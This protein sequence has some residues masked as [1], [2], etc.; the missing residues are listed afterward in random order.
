MADPNPIRPFMRAVA[1]LA[2]IAAAGAAS[3]VQAESAFG[4]PRSV[5]AKYDVRWFGILVYDGKFKVTLNEGSYK[6]EFT[7]NARGPVDLATR[8]RIHWYLSGTREGRRFFPVA[9]DQHYKWR[10]K[11][12]RITMS[13]RADGSVVTRIVPPESPGKRKPVPADM[14]RGTV[15]PVSALLNAVHAQ[16]AGGRCG[17]TFRAFEG[18]RR[19]DAR[20][21][22]VRK[23]KRPYTSL[24]SIPNDAQLCHFHIDRLAGF[25][26]RHMRNY[27]DPLP[28]AELW[29]V[30]FKQH[31]FWLPV[32]IRV[33]TAWAPIVA[34]L[35]RLKIVAGPGGR[36]KN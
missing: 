18:R 26:P 20:I 25:R 33:Q 22:F 15:D 31:G 4:G 6:A 10:K 5:E 12:R 13:Y 8:A 17:G 36:A 27:P 3:P 24:K 34:R 9:V 14:Q 32:V 28:P 29:I 2:V 19:A 16:T 11:Y 7:A 23:S 1:V 30:R 21:A 35:S